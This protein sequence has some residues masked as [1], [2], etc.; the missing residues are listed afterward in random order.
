MEELCRFST[1]YQQVAMICRQV[2]DMQS[3]LQ[4][5]LVDEMAAVVDAMS[6]EALGE[7]LRMTLSNTVAVS[8]LRSIEALGP[9]RGLVLPLPLNIIA[10]VGDRMTLTADDRRAL[11]T[12]SLML[13]MLDGGQRSHSKSDSLGLDVL[14]NVANTFRTGTVVVRGA[15]E[16]MPIMPEILPGL[17]LTAEKF[18]TKLLRRWALRFADDLDQGQ[19]SPAA[20]LPSQP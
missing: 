15:G 3:A 4:E 18:V 20:G 6:R 7:A 19:S 2:H 9:L 17:Q 14:E 10:G 13:E 12:L 5:L 16:L 11:D 1:P 8:A